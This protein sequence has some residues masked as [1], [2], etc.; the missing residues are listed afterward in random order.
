MGKPELA[1]DPRFREHAA[2]GANMAEIDSVIA[3]WTSTL[4]TDDILDQLSR[5]KVPAGRIFTA[6]DM[7]ADAQYAARDM[8]LRL[9]NRAGVELPVTGIVP[10]LSRTPGVVESA[11]PQLGS[12]T[13]AVLADLAA[14]GDDEWSRLRAGGVVA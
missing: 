3:E 7:L 4:C 12:H 10:K 8:V 5:H 14:V 9:T 13:R 6:P 2:R 1:E 11:G